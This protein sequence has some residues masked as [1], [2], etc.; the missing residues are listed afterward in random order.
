MDEN[1]IIVACACDERYAPGL[2]VTIRS[3]LEC[4]TDPRPVTLYVLGHKLSSITKEKLV[5]SWHGEI[6]VRFLEPD[7][8]PVANCNLRD[9]VSPAMY[10][11]ILLSTLLPEN[12][13]LYL[14]SDLLIRRDIGAL[15]DSDLM[16]NPLG[17]V[18]EVSNPRVSG[19]YGIQTYS[20]LGL[21]ADQPY[22]N[23]GVLLIDLAQWREKGYAKY[24]LALAHSST[25]ASRYWDQDSINAILGMHTTIL[26]A[27]W[28]SGVQA[29]KSCAAWE[30]QDAEQCAL[31]ERAENDPWIV[32]FLLKKP[33]ECRLDHPYAKEAAATLNRTA[34][35]D[36]TT[37][38]TGDP[39][40][41]ACGTDEHYAPGLAAMVHSV[42]WHHKSQRPIIAYILETDLTRAT[43]DRLLASW[44]DRRLQVHF[45]QPDLREF[46]D[47][48]R[49]RGV[50]AAMYFYLALPRLLPSIPKI[51][52]LDADMIFRADIEELWDTDLGSCPMGAVRELYTPTVASP[53]GLAPYRTLGIPADT[54]YCN[55]GLQLINLDLWRRE[56]IAE[57]IKEYTA[58][59]ADTVRYWDQDGVNAVLAGRW[60]ELDALWNVGAEGLMQTG[61][62]PKD[63]ASV[64]RM[65]RKAKLVHFVV[66][67]PWDPACTHPRA[68]LF[69]KTLKKTAWKSSIDM[70]QTGNRHVWNATLRTWLFPNAEKSAVG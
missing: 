66:T 33:W 28:N 24:I 4:K 50:H 5:A 15:W 62:I 31:A 23:S 26:D 40:V 17:A 7:C 67:K 29:L 53:Q 25:M 54:P 44:K 13:V 18:Q 20:A 48:P 47:L 57:Q 6:N 22:F 60:M 10:F 12:R 14:D 58:K 61:W 30:P 16:G 55:A 3:L 21:K 1:R 65:I 27:R 36:A 35:A 51:L 69:W 42:L 2:A 63:R 8:G 19:P 38:V 52:K 43:K 11:R 68:S 41:I 64:R 70:R 45:L 39:I 37:P 46:R 56:G 9:G 32:H 59:H 49:V 34:F